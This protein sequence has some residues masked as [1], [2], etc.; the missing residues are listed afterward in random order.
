[1]T[2]LPNVS[3]RL[4]K[5]KR[6]GRRVVR[7]ELGAALGADEARR[8]MLRGEALPRRAVADDDHA[9]VGP[10]APGA[11]E[12]AQRELDVLLGRDTADRD[13]H[14]RLGTGLPLRAQRRAARR[15]R[16]AGDVDAATDDREL[17][18]ARG[19]ELAPC[20]LRRHEGALRQVVE[21]AHQA[22]RRPGEHAEAVVPRVLVEVG[23]EVRGDRD[24]LRARRG[25]RRPRQRSGRREVHQIGTAL[26]NRRASGPGRARP[27]RR[28]GYIGMTQPAVRSS[29][30]ASS[31]ASPGWRGR[32]SS[33][34]WPRARR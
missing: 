11:L 22:E 29:S 20:R 5:R 30:L 27:K 3:V 4:G 24:A 14:R 2:T 21:A 18:E 32:I 34:R 25:E 13:E 10:V 19:G 23:A 33:T 17:V 16:E 26:R 31:R 7:G 8:R 12:G 1:M 28:S 9:Q 15:R 6:V